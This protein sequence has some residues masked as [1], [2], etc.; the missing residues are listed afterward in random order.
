MKQKRVSE[1]QIIGIFKEHEAGIADADL[2]C[3]Q[4]ALNRGSD[5][6]LMIYRSCVFDLRAVSAQ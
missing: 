5:S 4:S 1:E 2:C 3:C 6:Q